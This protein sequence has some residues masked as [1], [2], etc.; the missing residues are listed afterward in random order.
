MFTYYTQNSRHLRAYEQRTKPVIRHLRC[1]YSNAIYKL[2]LNLVY[3]QQNQCHIRCATVQCKV[4][5]STIVWLN[6]II[7]K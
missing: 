6:I 2:H 3:K 4:A 7:L 1:L 5:L